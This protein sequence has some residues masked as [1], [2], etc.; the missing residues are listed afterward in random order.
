MVLPYYDQCPDRDALL[1]I[2]YFVTQAV[3][4][5]DGEEVQQL[6]RERERAAEKGWVGG[7]E[8]E[9]GR[10]GHNSR[11]RTR[12]QTITRESNRDQTITN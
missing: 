1:K 9:R 5:S 6:K 3:S 7:R 12:D 2:S 4:V 10:E 11:T 8:G